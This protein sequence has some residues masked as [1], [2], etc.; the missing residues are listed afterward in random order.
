[1]HV[2]FVR[3]SSGWVSLL[4]TVHANVRVVLAFQLYVWGR[5]EEGILCQPADDGVISRVRR[6]R[7][8]SYAPYVLTYAAHVY[9]KKKIKTM[10][11]T[12]SY[13][14]TYDTC[15]FTWKLSFFYYWWEMR[16]HALRSGHL[17]L[18]CNKS[19]LLLWHYWDRDNLRSTASELGF[20]CKF[21]PRLLY[22]V[23]W[24]LY[25]LSN[26]QISFSSAAIA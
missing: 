15:Y 9:H 26:L 13:L 4:Y 22:F 19:S 12:A 24:L 11:T 10:T 7:R 17:V 6:R 16:T 18:Q 21:D 25:I 3:W 14:R 2:V 20:C 5:R 1:M 23:L 8:N